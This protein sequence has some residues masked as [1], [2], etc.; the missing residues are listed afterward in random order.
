MGCETVDPLVG[1]H[2]H[3]EFRTPYMSQS[4]GQKRGNS[5]VY[6]QRRY[7]IQ[8]LDS[9]ALEASKTN[10][11]LSTGSARP[12]LNMALPPL[13]WQTYDIF[14]KPAV[15]QDGKKIAGTELTVIHKGCAVH[16]NTLVTNKTGAGKEEGPE[17]LPLWLQDHGDPVVFRNIW[18]VPAVRLPLATRTE[19]LDQLLTDLSVHGRLPGS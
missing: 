5:G 6:L 13:V 10:V 1:G 2:L 11:V 17:P 16:Y 8:V 4:S 14:F 19:K 7:E 9:F 15:F 18:L 3:V 12:D